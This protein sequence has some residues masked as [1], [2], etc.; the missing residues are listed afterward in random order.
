MEEIRYKYSRESPVINSTEILIKK[1]EGAS[2]KISEQIPG[3][4]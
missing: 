1:P 3:G 2:N 4:M